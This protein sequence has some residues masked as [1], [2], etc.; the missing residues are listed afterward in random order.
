M[1]VTNPAESQKETTVSSMNN[2]SHSRHPSAWPKETSG[3]I[4]LTESILMYLL[5]HGQQSTQLRYQNPLLDSTYLMGK[6]VEDKMD[7]AYSIN[8]K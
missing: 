6:Q 4:T 8:T 1:A 5:H 3:I 7:P 2:P